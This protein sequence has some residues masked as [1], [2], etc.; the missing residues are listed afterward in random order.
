LDEVELVHSRVDDAYCGVRYLRGK[1]TLTAA[2]DTC[3]ERRRSLRRAIPARKGHAHCAVR[4]L[5]GNATGVAGTGC[6]S[7]TNP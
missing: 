4:Y 5:R 6:G 1:A 2:C 3:T 7:E